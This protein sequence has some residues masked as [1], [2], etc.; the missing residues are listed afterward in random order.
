M[1]LPE[2]S[3]T[4]RRAQLPRSRELTAGDGECR[5][6]ARF[7]LEV[8]VRGD[9]RCQQFPFQPLNFCLVVALPC[10][11]DVSAAFDTASNASALRPSRASNCPSTTRNHE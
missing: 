9:A 10:R 2:A 3:Q 7:G 4:A 1:A 11:L 8:G 6:K 5:L